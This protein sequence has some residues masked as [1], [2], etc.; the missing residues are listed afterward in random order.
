MTYL[1]NEKL[2]DLTPYD[3]HRTANAIYMDANESFL[4]MPEVIRQSVLAA[5]GKVDFNR[6][7]DP[8]AYECCKAFGDYYGAD[9]AMITAGNGSDELISIILSGF[10]AKG[11]R[12]LLTDPDFSMYA[13]YA[14]ISEL[15]ITRYKKDTEFRIIP[16]DLISLA[17]EKGCKGV[18]L[19]NPC[20]PTSQGIDKAGL[21]RVISEL[22]DLLVIVDEAYMD[23]WDQSLINEVGDFDNLIILRTASKA[24][25]AASIRLGF[26]VARENLTKG[27][28]SV[29]SPYN[30]SSTTQAAGVALLSHPDSHKKALKEILTGRDYLMSELAKLEAGWAKTPNAFSLV[31]APKT[32][33]VVLRFSDKAKH[34]EI[35]NYMKKSG[36]AIRCFP[37]FLRVTVG[38]D[39]E[40]RAFLGA[41]AEI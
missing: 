11:D 21:R 10:F 18:V 12:I 5:I 4:P 39:Y 40:N 37:D 36:I 20:N 3:A 26:A 41:L 24:F 6:Y 30:V 35:Y 14:G 22:S 23:F 33:F 29:K 9:P 31:A 15:E 38:S 13:V 34:I 2:R 17:K 19:S 28:R 8:L 25:G 16:E 1:I 32:N 27:I 7:P